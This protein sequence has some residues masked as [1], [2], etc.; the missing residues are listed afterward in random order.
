MIL[1]EYRVWL[2]LG[3]VWFE[4]GNDFFFIIRVSIMTV[5][6]IPGSHVNHIHPPSC[7]IDVIFM[8]YDTLIAM[9]LM[10]YGYSIHISLL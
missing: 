1:S 4:F 9:I 5:I 3:L 6:D 7:F 8:L 10:L 2:G